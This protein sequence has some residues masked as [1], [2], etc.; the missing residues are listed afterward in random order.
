MRV[1]SILSNEDGFSIHF[2][3]RQANEIA[4]VLATLCSSLASPMVW[5]EPPYDVIPQL[6]DICYGH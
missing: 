6:D 4:Y 5:H 1:V 2:V 3:R